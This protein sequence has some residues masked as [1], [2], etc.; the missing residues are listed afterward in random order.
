MNDFIIMKNSNFTPKQHNSDMSKNENI[1][2]VSF[3]DIIR[4][5]IINSKRQKRQSV[6]K[7]KKEK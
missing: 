4:T 3:E 7:E 5:A 2:Y 1:K 6:T